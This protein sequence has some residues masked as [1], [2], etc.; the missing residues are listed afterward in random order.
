MGGGWA[1]DTAR[2][3]ADQE[4]EEEDEDVQQGEK[5]GRCVGEEERDARERAMY[6]GHAMANIATTPTTPFAIAIPTHT[7]TPNAIASFKG[8]CKNHESEL[9]PAARTQSKTTK[10]T[11]LSN[12]SKVL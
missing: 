11:D 2:G 5:D 6:V 7:P 10:N 3:G 9:P 1:G 12:P 8:Q 4:G